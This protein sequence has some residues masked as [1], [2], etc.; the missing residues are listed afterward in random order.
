MSKEYTAKSITVLKDLQAVRLRSAMYIG[1]TSFRGFHHIFQEVLDNSIDEAL[2]GYCKNINVI[3]HKDNSITVIDDGRGIPTDIHP[4]EGKSALEL[5]MTVLH[6]GGKFDKSTY[7]ISGGLHGVGVSVTN[8]LS[9]FL[10]VK[11]YRD[12]KIFHQR[13]E[14]GR[15]VSEV[16]V[17][18]DTEK[19]G[20][21]ITFLPDDEIFTVNE[22]DYDYIKKRLR[23]LAYLNAGLRIS[24]EDERTDS[25][26]EFIFEG[27]LKEFVKDLNKGKNVLSDPIYVN[28]ENSISVEIAMQYNDSYNTKLYS[29]VNNINTVEGGTHEEGFRTALTRV[30]NEYDRKNNISD[31]KLTGD[32]VKEGLTCVISIKVPEPQ[33]EGQTKTKLG[34]SNVKGLVSSVVYESLNNYFEEN[35]SVAKLICNKIIGAAKAREAARKARELA[36]RKTAFES[37]SLPGKLADCSE[38]DPTKCELFIVEGDSAAGT[39][40]SARDRKFQAIL[41]L[42]GKI[43]NVEKARLDKLFKNEQITNLITALGCGIGEEFNINKLRY[44]KVI[45]LTDADSVTGDT[46]LLLF[47]KNNEIEFNYIG[48]FVNDCITP[49]EYK[50]S[51]F[52]INPGKHQVKKITNIVKH[53]L[54]T[55][56]YEIKTNLGYSVKATSYHSVFVYDGSNIVTK[57]SNEI[58]TNDY[59]LIPKKLPRTDRDYSVDLSKD[60]EA[61]NV[62]ASLKK[63]ILKKIPDESYVDLRLDEWN[64]LKKIRMASGIS[65]KK[66]SELLN[67]YFTIIEQWETKIDNVMPK[68]DLFRKYIKILNVNERDIEFKLFVPINEINLDRI[69]CNNFYLKNHTRRLKLKVDIDKYLV[70]LLGWYIGDGTRSRGKKNPYRFSL[71]IG[72]DKHHYLNRIKSS[73]K[74]S[75]DC[76]VILD[77]NVRNSLMVHFNS[78]TFELF[79][80]YLG[81]YGKKANEKFVPNIIFNLK[82]ELQVSFLEGLLHSDGFAYVGKTRGKDGKPSFGHSTTSKILA[83]GIVFLYRQIG[84]LPSV[85]KSRAKDHLYKNILIK[86]NYDSYNIMIGS[87][88][89]LIKTNDIW[90]NHKNAIVLTSHLS[91]VKK[92]KNRKY[93]IDVNE[94]FQG[95]KVLSVK[96]IENKDKF[97]YDIGVDINRSFIGGV[98]GLTLHNSDGNHI[99]CLLLTFF[100]RYMPELIKNGYVYVAQPPLFK[101]IKNKKTTYIRDEENL[102]IALKEQGNENVVVQRFKGLGEMDANELEET[103]MDIQKRVLKRIN[104]EDAVE[105]DNIFNI[106]MGEEVEPRRDF[107]IKY[108]KEANIDV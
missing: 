105:A 107:I 9:K 2:A 39:G 62:Y 53:P 80:K 63:S 6:A 3:I 20:T 19:K 103:V 45:I 66:M 35:P 87:V 37:G 75:L 74:K 68:Y 16:E 83:E 95:V 14:R 96:K 46:P 60:V 86:S 61:K 93:V 97:V 52:S 13:Y 43:L 30:I 1:D 89:Q 90:K 108:S 77:D 40:I 10:D 24:L 98:G 85:I 78:F 91:L 29:F 15:K 32:D 36:R 54:K 34:N 8:A 21:E 47:N 104:V 71:C 101:I 41:P 27:G 92:W 50:I 55:N 69:D 5:V 12:G 102:K 99:S 100:Y 22:F 33:F 76:N 18:G 56:L 70:Y 72:N 73:I 65:R 88:E 67:I 25:K 81:L 58:T 11:V 84:V 42:R 49:Q 17:L 23:E 79:L 4:E 26:E 57:K 28:K 64:K 82:K 38:R 59:V 51:S 31:I 48:N 106:L 94:D 7:K 44:H